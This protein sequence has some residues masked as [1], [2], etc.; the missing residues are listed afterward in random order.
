MWL[1]PKI[2]NDVERIHERLKLKLQVRKVVQNC[3][4]Q[5]KN[6]SASIKDRLEKY[7]SVAILDEDVAI[8]IAVLLFHFWS[9]KFVS[10]TCEK[11]SDQ[12]QEY[13]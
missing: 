5:N 8:E 1:C 2:V 4:D 6:H 13:D 7:S 9:I 11:E 10:V 12:Y 3:G